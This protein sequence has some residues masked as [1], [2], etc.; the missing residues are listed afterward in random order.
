MW[1]MTDMLAKE[2]KLSGIRKTSPQ[3]TM[4]AINTSSGPAW[5]RMKLISH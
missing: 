5:M 3:Q 4:M 1:F 2:S